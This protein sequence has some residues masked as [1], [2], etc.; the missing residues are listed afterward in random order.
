ML[1][2]LRITNFAI[3]EELDVAFHDG[4]NVLTGE[5]GA[6]KSIIIGALNLVLGSR[7][8][9]DQVRSGQ[10]SAVVEAR[11]RVEDAATRAL[12]EEMGL[13]L[14]DDTLLVRRVLSA[15]DKNR[16]FINGAGV[17]VA[18]LERIGRRLVDLHGQHDHQSLLHPET[19]VELL[20][21]F[22]NLDAVRNAFSAAFQEHQAAAQK[23]RQAQTELSSRLQRQ[24]LLR[25]QIQEI[26][27]AAPDPEEEERLLAERNRLRHAEQLHQALTVAL[28]HLAEGAGCVLERLGRVRRDL[29]PLTA[30]DASLSPQARRTDTAFFETEELAAE[31]RD[32]LQSLEFSPARQET[33]EERFQ[34]LNGLKRK[35]GGDLPAVLQH[36]EDIGRELASLTLSGEARA[37]LE[38][39]V[40][41]LAGILTRQAALL[42][43][44]REGAAVG[45]KKGAERELKDLSMKQVRFDI[46]FDYPEDA[47]SPAVFRKRRVSL[48]PTGLGRLEFVFS[49]NPGE[50]LRPLA[51]I[52]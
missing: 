9:T 34:I 21:R 25:F 24:D 18:Q 5:T 33:L 43:E 10:D 29:E 26:D 51:K 36:R 47:A 28:D 8:D 32:Y 40:E 37:A 45:L 19:H 49:P 20:D 17:T 22:G 35:Y 39:Q 13:P 2:H 30:L 41:S 38:K 6:G 52:A 23:L 50:A 4:L 3:I 42:A 16:V 11:F 31:L 48:T 27:E 15:K 12:L 46:R 44:A 1:E 14:E 7:A